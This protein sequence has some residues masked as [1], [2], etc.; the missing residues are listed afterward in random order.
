MKE[1]Y[2][3]FIKKID[4]A[5]RILDII[6]IR[7]LLTPFH[8]LKEN[9]PL[10]QEL[11]LQELRVIP[12]VRSLVDQTIDIAL[13]LLLVYSVSCLDFFLSTS[14]QKKLNLKKMIDEHESKVGRELTQKIH[15]IR[16][17]RNIVI[18][19]HEQSVDQIALKELNEKQIMGYKLNQTL[20]LTPEDIK[21]DLNSL[22]KIAEKV[23]SF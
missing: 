8:R 20:R 6:R 10:L 17:K 16:I 22:R 13:P 1:E 9:L 21:D 14:T 11:G 15:E 19:S 4:H 7:E 2:E 3:D 23:A 12:K 18:H 5:E